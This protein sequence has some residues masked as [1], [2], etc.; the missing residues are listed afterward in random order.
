MKEESFE[1]IEENLLRWESLGSKKVPNGAYVVGH[2]PDL[3]I[4]AYLHTLYPPLNDEDIRSL[5]AIIERPLPQDLK[6]FYK[7]SNGIHMFS[8]SLSFSGLRGHYSRTFDQNA[9]DN[10]RQPFNLADSNIFE[11]PR[12][13]KESF[14]YFGFYHWDGSQLA[15]C[16]ESPEVYLCAPRSSQIL[17]TW[18]TFDEMLTSEVKRLA[19]LF[20]KNGK[21]ID[22][23]VPTIP[24]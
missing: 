24:T 4:E 6:D 19:L 10:A 7:C 1:E 23:D 18:P 3:G 21:E 15:M 12:G 9:F 17:L 22:E 2:I 14:V 16:P 13:S 11:R 8:G 20:G 5:E